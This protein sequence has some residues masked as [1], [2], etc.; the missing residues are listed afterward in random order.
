MRKHLPLVT[1]ALLGASVCIPAAWAETSQQ[2]LT[3]EVRH[4]LVLLPYY[5]VFDNLEFK[6]DNSGHVTL[7]GQVTNPTLKDDAGR[8]VQG[9]SDVQGVTND[10]EVLPLSPN[11]NQIRLQEYRAIYSFPSLQKYATMAVPTIHIIV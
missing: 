6:V 11:D 10:I 8:V 4:Q 1:L 5:S 7:M 9:I 3:R 2:A